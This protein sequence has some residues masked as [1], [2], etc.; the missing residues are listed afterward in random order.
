MKIIGWTA[1]ITVSVV[2]YVLWSGYVLSVLWGWFVAETFGVTEITVLQ[3]AGLMAL[4]AMGQTVGKSSKDNRPFHEMMIAALV[5]AAKMP[6]ASLA[7]GFII[8][9]FI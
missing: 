5:T 1:T 8:H 4:I 3:A 7:T 6:A 9:Q 2:L